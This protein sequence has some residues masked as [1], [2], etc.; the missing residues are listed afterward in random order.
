MK[1]YVF[2]VSK[3][4]E[5]LLEEVLSLPCG[6]VLQRAGDIGH[7]NGNAFFEKKLNEVLKL[8]GKEP[9]VE[10]YNEVMDFGCPSE[11]MVSEAIKF[12]QAEYPNYPNSTEH[13]FVRKYGDWFCIKCQADLLVISQSRTLFCRDEPKFC[14]CNSDEHDLNDEDYSDY[15][16][17]ELNYLNDKDFENFMNSIL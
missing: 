7:Q 5:I 6:R 10:L 15:L 1:N 13:G 2:E 3:P 11:D 12:L 9:E 16:N 4:F 8:Q 14:F 17:D